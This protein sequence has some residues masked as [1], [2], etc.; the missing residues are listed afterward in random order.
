MSKEYVVFT[1]KMKK[2]YTI[3]APN[4][5]PI[6]FKLVVEALNASGYHAEL[7]ETEGPHIREMGLRYV[8][9]DMCYPALL[10]IGQFLDAIESGKYDPHKVALIM[11]QTGGG[12]RASNYIYLLRK[13]LARAGYDYVPVISLSMQ[14]IEKHPGFKTDLALWQKLVHAVAY[15]DLIHSLQRQ[16]LP[17]EVYPYQTREVTN[18][19]IEYLSREIGTNKLYMTKRKKNY[20]A[21]I[22]DFKNIPLREE[23]RIKVGIVG[24]IY[25][26]FSPLANN[27]LEDFLQEEGAE[28][29][30]AGLLD[31]FLY[32]VYAGKMD[33]TLYGDRWLSSTIMNMAYAYLKKKQNE[34]IGIMQEECDFTPPTPF[35]HVVSLVEGYVSLGAKM[36]EGWL[37]VAEMLELA[38]RGVNNIICAQPFGCL[39]NHIFGKGMMKPLKEKNPHLNI[40]AIDYDAGASGVNQENRIKLMLEMAESV[41][42]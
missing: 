17:Y 14:G 3:L 31:F 15:G 39:P 12:C 30:A 25:V 10:V 37:L 38:E 26:K 20:R 1:K 11:F 7:L 27:N 5:L 16:C 22:R 33:H 35:D 41:N 8:H 29:V 23:K 9:N 28:V 19:W 24:E 4:M 6:H 2:E 18:R 13:A 42:V 34:M 21:I 32:C 40:V 36:G